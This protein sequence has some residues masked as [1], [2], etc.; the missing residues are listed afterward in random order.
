MK[1]SYSDCNGKW[2]TIKQSAEDRTMKTSM[3]SFTDVRKYNFIQMMKAWEG[4]PE[5]GILERIQA[6]RSK[7]SHCF[8]LARLINLT[9]QDYSRCRVKTDLPT[10]KVGAEMAQWIDFFQ[11]KKKIN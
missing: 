9:K 3:E 5:Q 6:G 1:V 10:I 7:Y 11:I 2:V 4:R 8:T